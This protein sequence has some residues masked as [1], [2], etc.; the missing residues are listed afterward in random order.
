MSPGKHVQNPAILLDYSDLRGCFS[1]HLLQLSAVRTHDDLSDHSPTFSPYSMG[2][3]EDKSSL[4]CH[5]VGVCGYGVMKSRGP[6]FVVGVIRPFD[7]K[8]LTSTPRLF[9]PDAVRTTI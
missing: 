9:G 1:P 3:T 4:N 7:Q 8:P 5:I 6:V 2:P